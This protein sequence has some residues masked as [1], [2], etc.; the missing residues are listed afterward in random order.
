MDKKRPTREQ[1]LV[2]WARPSL[3]DIRRLSRIMD[4]KLEGQYSAK[5]A[6]KIAKLAYQCL[7]QNPKSRP[8]MSTVVETLEPLPEMKS[9]IP[10]G[11]FVYTVAPA[12]VPAEEVKKPAAAEEEEGRKTSPRGV[13]EEMRRRRRRRHPGERP[14]PGLMSR[15]RKEKT[16]FNFTDSQLY[17]SSGTRHRGRDA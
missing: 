5:G 4:P 1:H 14:H 12:P 2:D 10:M 16:E 7:R 13:G 8:L 9:D 11:H 17:K 3:N 6:L 15:S